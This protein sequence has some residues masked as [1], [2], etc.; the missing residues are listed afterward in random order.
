MREFNERTWLAWLVKVRV[1]VITFLLVIELAIVRL[2]DTNVPER[3][4]LGAILL[5]YLA[6]A[7]HAVLRQYTQN[8]QV[9]SRL[10]VVTDLAFATAVVYLTGGIDTS[11]NFL[12]PL[13]IFMASI[14]LSSTWTYLVA[15][16]SFIFF[17]AMVELSY[18]D[19]VPS[20]SITHP[21]TKSLQAII[22]INLFAYLAIAYLS[23]KLSNRLRQ[24]HVELK[25]K[26][27]ALEDLQ[28]LHENIIN[29]MSGGLITTDLD[30]RVR[31]VN[32]AGQRLLERA[33]TELA[34]KPV[35]HIFLDRLPPVESGAARGEVRCANLSGA[36][37]TF[38]VTG[39]ALEVH[40]RGVIGYVYTLDDLTDIRRLEREV[41]MRDRLAAIGRMASGIA[42]EIRNPLSSI[43]GSVQVLSGISELDGEQRTLVDIAVRESERLNAIISDFLVYARDKNYK[44]APHN[45][46]PLLEETLSALEEH[47]GGNSLQVVRRFEPAEA[48]AL[49]DRDRIRQVF[50]NICDTASRAMPLGGTLTVTLAP[51]GSDWRIAFA[52]TGKGFT[53]QQA[54]KVFEPFQ[55]QLDGATGLGL[56]IVYQIV[57]A[58]QGK[59]AVRS[60]P[61]GG[62]EFIVELKQAERG[63][64]KAAPAEV[65]AEVAHG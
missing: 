56:A 47:R 3:L 65:G 34:G 36:E 38:A 33:A 46:V 25:D 31:F 5:W 54:E 62:T 63:R 6:S 59:V 10:Q 16:L 21:D 18:F 50:W 49:V 51:A 28:A 7:L 11:F 19:L 40:D 9:Q 17:G 45:L 42:H 64:P 41:R 29:S 44:L 2:T 27:G 4:F 26:S 58:H 12:Y 55:A 1:I 23:S 57:Q 60:A 61:S 20:Y 14:L 32:P 39:S 22:F 30:G 24:V 35:A 13:V 37:K 52:D 53:T 8:Y 48:L 43:A 15:L